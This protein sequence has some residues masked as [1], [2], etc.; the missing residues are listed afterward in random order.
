MQFEAIGL[1]GAWLIHPERI[2]DNRGYFVRTFCV[3]EFGE[4]GLVTEFPQQFAA[5][6]S[7]GILTAK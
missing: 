6:T 2:G 3:N 7:S 4:R 5:C 1:G